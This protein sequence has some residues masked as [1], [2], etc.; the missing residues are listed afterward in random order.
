V[1]IVPSI[2]TVFE[3]MVTCDLYFPLVRW[4]EITQ[5]A[6]DVVVDFQH[7]QLTPKK[8]TWMT[9]KTRQRAGQIVTGLCDSIDLRE[10]FVAGYKVNVA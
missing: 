3:E 4:K 6:I 9:R 8:R 7:V 2:S 10:G 5:R 1:H